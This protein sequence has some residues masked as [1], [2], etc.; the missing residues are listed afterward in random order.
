M[1]QMFKSK[2]SALIAGLMVALFSP[3]A[4]A[5]GAGGLGPIV[6]AKLGGVEADVTSI[7]A[8]M[9]GVLSLFVLY[10]LIRKAIGK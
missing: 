6:L 9:V 1:L 2:T 7:L 4:M 10:T 5:S 3:L 8:L